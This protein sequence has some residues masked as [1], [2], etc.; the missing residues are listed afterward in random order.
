MR[1]L[2]CSINIF[3]NWLNI[4]WAKTDKKDQLDIYSIHRTNNN[5]PTNQ[6]T[7]QPI[8]PSYLVLFFS[9]FSFRC[10]ALYVVVVLLLPY[11]VCYSS[12]SVFAFD[13][14][15]LET[16]YVALLFIVD[17]LHPPLFVFIAHL[18]SIFW[19][20][21]IRNVSLLRWFLFGICVCLAGALACILFSVSN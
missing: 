2:R 15:L 12:V 14:S 19:Q 21:I 1:L 20:R 8:P 4:F 3:N 16:L 13:G 9:P 11:P 6:P 17:F 7:N 5:H 18:H 10:V